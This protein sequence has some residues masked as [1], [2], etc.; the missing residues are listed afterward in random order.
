MSSYPP[1]FFLT[2]SEVARPC[3]PTRVIPSY[4]DA[5]K[6]MRAVTCVIFTQRGRRPC[7]LTRELSFPSEAAKAM[8]EDLARAALDAEEAASA[9]AAAR[10]AAAEERRA[11]AKELHTTEHMLE[12]TQYAME[13]LK[14]RIKTE[15]EARLVR[16]GA[17]RLDAHGV[18]LSMHVT[19]QRLLDGASPR[20]PA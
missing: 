5:A 7:G 13:S 6:A 16:F 12:E 19:A 14:F 20:S 15:A 2:C 11:A 4:S 1:L 10:A 3:G 9:A 17:S 18:K 8:A